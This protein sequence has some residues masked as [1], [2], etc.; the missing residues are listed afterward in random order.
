MLDSGKKRGR[1][2][3]D[4]MAETPVFPAFSGENG[5]AFFISYAYND[6]CFEG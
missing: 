3:V 5:F 2:F 6:T 1:Y 4:D